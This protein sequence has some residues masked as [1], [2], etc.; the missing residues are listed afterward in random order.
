M[1]TDK[2]SIGV[3]TMFNALG[4]ATSYFMMSLTIWMTPLD[5]QTKGIFG[6]GVFMLTLSLV[7]FVKYR[8]DARKMADRI[9]QIEAAKN[10][11]LLEE[12]V[13]D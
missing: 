4:V 8:M 12:F 13:S 5:L 10:E 11:K 3:Y 7:N 1:T 2:D 6:M 9:D